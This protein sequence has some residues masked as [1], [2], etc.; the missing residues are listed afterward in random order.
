VGKGLHLAWRPVIERRHDDPP[1]P[2]H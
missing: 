1:R 2:T